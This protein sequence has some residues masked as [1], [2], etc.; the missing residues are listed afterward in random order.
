MRGSWRTGAAVVLALVW[1]IAAGSARAQGPFGTGFRAFAPDERR[2]G[3]V[4]GVYVPNWEPTSAT[5][6][7]LQPGSVTHALYAFLRIC[8]PGQLPKDQAVCAGK[9]D[10]QLATSATV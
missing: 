1:A 2:A 7:R 4:V 10:F 6:D 8:G 3:A 5:L 9:Q